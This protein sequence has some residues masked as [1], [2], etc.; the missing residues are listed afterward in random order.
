MNC[1]QME[2]VILVLLKVEAVIVWTLAGTALWLG[3]PDLAQPLAMLG[4]ALINALLNR[5][6][7]D[8]GV[9]SPR[10]SARLFGLADG[11]LDLM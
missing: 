7:K 10:S 3:R 8:R 11:R 2:G 9:E 6:Q 4:T 1:K 5:Y